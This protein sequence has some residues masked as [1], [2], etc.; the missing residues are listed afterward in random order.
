V[1]GFDIQEPHTHM[2]KHL[3]SKRKFIFIM[4]VCISEK[5]QFVWDSYVSTITNKGRKP[6]R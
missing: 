3:I 6:A 1:T 2:H 5:P 4:I